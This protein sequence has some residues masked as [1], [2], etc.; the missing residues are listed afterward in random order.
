MGHLFLVID[1]SHFIDIKT[2]KNKVSS[3]RSRLRSSADSVLVAGDLEFEGLEKRKNA[4][5]ISDYVYS[6]LQNIADEFDFSLEIE[7]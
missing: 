3:I 5:E 7:S 6:E 2:F 4:I 1:P